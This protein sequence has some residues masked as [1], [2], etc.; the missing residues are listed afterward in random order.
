[1]ADFPLKSSMCGTTRT[2][3]NARLPL[4]KQPG[5]LPPGR[6]PQFGMPRSVGRRSAEIGGLGRR[7]RKRD[8]FV[9]SWNS[10][11]K[12]PGGCPDARPANPRKPETAM[13]RTESDSLRSFSK[14]LFG[15]DPSLFMPWNQGT[16]LFF[17]V[18]QSV[19]GHIA[20]WTGTKHP[21]RAVLVCG[22]CP[23]GPQISWIPPGRSQWTS[24]FSACRA[25]KQ[26][27]T[28]PSLRSPPRNTLRRWDLSS[29][30]GRPRC[31]NRICTLCGTQIR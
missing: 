27:G 16:V 22:T 23:P 13:I 18:L 25:E 6:I 7:V 5:L 9:S 2:P 24:S 26:N 28:G 17:G 29:A 11:R 12:L 19:L 15:H 1:M 8:G 10:P 21:S 4:W 14:M 20:S 30:A 31:R 3:L